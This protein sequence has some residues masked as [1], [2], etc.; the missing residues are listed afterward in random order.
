MSPHPDTIL[1][2]RASWTL[3]QLIYSEMFEWWA[4]W[5]LIPSSMNFLLIWAVEH[6]LITVLIAWSHLL[7]R[8]TP[9]SV[10]HYFLSIYCLAITLLLSCFL[11]FGSVIIYFKN[12]F[13]ILNLNIYW[14]NSCKIILLWYLSRV[15]IVIYIVKTI[16]DVTKSNFLWFVFFSLINEKFFEQK[17][18]K[19][20]CCVPFFKL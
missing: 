18:T 17:Y 1:S 12:S 3:L 10:D 4:T 15:S 20:F 9:V 8:R 7:I 5:I 13:G 11:S 14:F 19:I 2:A 16:F 6:V